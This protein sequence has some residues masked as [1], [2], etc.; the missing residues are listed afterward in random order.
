MKK[1]KI[2]LV[3][4][5][6][7]SVLMD[8]HI[9]PVDPM[10]I[11]DEDIP[12]SSGIRNLTASEW[13]DKMTVGWNLGNAL[14]GGT[15]EYRNLNG[16]Y[17][18]AFYEN[19]TGNPITTQEMINK[20]RDAGFNTI[21]IPVLWY[22]NLQSDGRISDSWMKRVEEVVQYA[23]NADMQVILCTA[24]R[25]YIRA[26]LKEIDEMKSR[27]ENIW[28]QV[29]VHFKDYD[30]RL[31]FE[32]INE[33]LTEEPTSNGVYNWSVTS[34]GVEALNL[35]TQS[36][37]DV[38]RES[39]GN[40]KERVLFC[41]TWGCNPNGLAVEGFQVPSDTAEDGLVISI[42]SY[43]GISNE[44]LDKE[45]QIVKQKFVDYGIPVV[46][47][48][49]G[50]LGDGSL[51]E[52]ARSVH[53][54]NF[55]KMTGQYGIKCCWWDNNIMTNYGILNRTTL[56]WEY[57]LLVSGMLQGE[58]NITNEDEVVQISGTGQY[59]LQQRDS[60]AVTT[61]IK[62]EQKKTY[63]IQLDFV[64]TYIR[65]KEVCG[66]DA[67]GN[68]IDTVN[69]EEYTSLRAFEYLPATGVAYFEVVL[70]NPWAKKAF[71]YYTD[72]LENGVIL[73][74]NAMEESEYVENSMHT[75]SFA[76]DKDKKCL[77]VAGVV[78]HKHMLLFSQGREF[79]I[80]GLDAQKNLVQESEYTTSLDFV[81]ADKV[82]YI[83]V[84]FK[85]GGDGEI[86]VSYASDGSRVYL[87]GKDMVV[88]SDKVIFTSTDGW[89]EG[90]YNEKTGEVIEAADKIYYAQYISVG[91]QEVITF[92]MNQNVAKL[93][94]IGLDSN[95]E[96]VIDYGAFMDGTN[97]YINNEDVKYLAV[98]LY[99][100]KKNMNKIEY[101]KAFDNG[102]VI[103][104]ERGEK[105]SFELE[106]K[107]ALN[108][109]LLG[110]YPNEKNQEVSISDPS[111]YFTGVNYAT[112]ELIGVGEIDR[113][114]GVFVELGSLYLYEYD[115]EG[116]LINKVMCRK[117]TI[118]NL[119]DNTTHIRLVGT[120]AARKNDT[121]QILYN[122]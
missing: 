63:L 5:L 41:D 46:Y 120:F 95:Y 82:C 66:Y 23:L 119:N 45:I 21:R 64:Q 118:I 37:V 32:C 93:W 25:N 77:S 79:K 39:G 96:A 34:G 122:K 55:I 49:F 40:N 15:E 84:Q 4:V 73:C 115:V 80:L 117:S 24:D 60:E 104:I 44:L 94:A 101:Q 18:A 68:K 110:I 30:S 83:E 106:K 105:K 72:A 75:E 98:Y 88:Q 121:I 35:L 62:A 91:Y 103:A 78:N 11:S 107:F 99:P 13:V 3:M 31:A 20:V 71:S 85:D 81:C 28:G 116:N 47:T 42:H 26:D 86:T 38:I 58:C 61:K 112:T 27:L 50:S 9:T 19:L 90:A 53:A 92:S 14:G 111:T 108:E 89:N 113:T 69:F 22:Y 87:T 114:F 54:E 10:I 16:Q 100:N 109:L 1:I 8:Y 70:H 57:P 102:Y 12:T 56:E 48:E 67:Q 17:E 65:L 29:A 2:V 43:S 76:I 7:V 33:I 52:E 59:Q 97:L 6:L 36:W 51:S 74:I